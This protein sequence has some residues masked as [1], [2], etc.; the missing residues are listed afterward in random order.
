MC[1]VKLALHQEQKH[2]T[3]MIIL[4]DAPKYLS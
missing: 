4:Y 3:M 1:K 2:K